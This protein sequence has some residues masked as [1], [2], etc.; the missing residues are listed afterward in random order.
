MAARLTRAKK[1]ISTARIPY[2]VPGANE[3]HE[4]RLSLVVSLNTKGVL[5]MRA[6]TLAA[7]APHERVLTIR[8]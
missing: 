4:A 7:G 1:K 8:D 2:R 3:L 5:E 6:W